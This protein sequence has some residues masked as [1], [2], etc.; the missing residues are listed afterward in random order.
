MLVSPSIIGWQDKHGHSDGRQRATHRAIDPN[1]G[2]FECPKAEHRQTR[3]VTCRSTSSSDL[4]PVFQTLLI[5][6]FG[7]VS[8]RANEVGRQSTPRS[9]HWSGCLAL[10]A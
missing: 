8:E 4:R 1:A 7:S 9:N 6:L 2:S 10:A 3:E 5:A